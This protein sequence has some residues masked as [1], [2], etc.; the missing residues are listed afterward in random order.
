MPSDDDVVSRNPVEGVRGVAVPGRDDHVRGYQRAA[1][2]VMP[3]VRQGDRVWISHAGHLAARRDRERER[4]WAKRGKRR[5][6]Y[7]VRDDERVG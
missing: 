2:E 1:A 3:A 5:I 4:D 7:V 6:R